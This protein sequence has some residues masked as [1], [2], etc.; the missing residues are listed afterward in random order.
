MRAMDHPDYRYSPW[1]PER[2]QAAS[3]RAKA[4]IAR[5]CAMN[6][7]WP[8][9]A[10]VVPSWAGRAKRKRQD[11][12]AADRKILGDLWIQRS[13]RLTA[14]Q[15]G[16]ILARPKE[17]IYAKA[18]QMG[19]PPRN[20]GQRSMRDKADA[21]DFVTSRGPRQPKKHGGSQRRFHGVEN[22]KGPK[23]TLEP[24]DPRS[25]AGTTVFPTTVIP[26]SKLVRVLKSGVNSRKIGREVAKGRLAGAPI[27]T[28]TLEERATCPRSCL[29]WSRC[30]GNNMHFAQRIFDDGTLTR[31]LWGEL[32][33]LAA[34]HAKGFLVRLHVLG[35]FYSIEY[36]EFW[37]QA[38]ADFA[39]LNVFG[40]TARMP[41]DP[42]GVAIAEMMA[43][44]YERCRIRFSGLR[45][46][47]DG[48]IVINSEEEKIGII[49]PAEQDPDRCCATCALCWNSN[50]TISFLRH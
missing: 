29:E 25:R 23:I 35:D 46:E 4:R 34:E 27:F 2:R 50:K 30:Y 3:E 8:A 49:C 41:P 43:A 14:E 18:H 12:T 21:F 24:W 33:S 48:S 37:R 45:S 1:T 26:A 9:T 11:W 7:H 22:N 15:I 13:P 20:K 39:A 47:E 44:N 42:I 38:L 5:E 19:L 16:D 36:V 28:L 32:A 17:A 31:R 10:S 40:F 6:E